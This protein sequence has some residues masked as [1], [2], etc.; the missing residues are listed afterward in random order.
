MFVFPQRSGMSLTIDQLLLDKP[1]GDWFTEPSPNFVAMATRIGPTTFCTVWLNRPSPKPPGRPKHLWSICHTSRLTGDIVQIFGNKF[2]AFGCLNQ[3]S[4]NN[5]LSSAM[6]RT[7]CQKW[8]DS[9][10]KQKRSS[11]LKGCDTQT[12]PIVEN[13]DS[14][15]GAEIKIRQIRPSAKFRV[16]WAHCT[17]LWQQQYPWAHA[18]PRH[19]LPIKSKPCKQWLRYWQ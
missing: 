11:N 17:V 5:V 4:K 19:T 10:E 14:L 3:K 9:I 1:V 6:R 12:E 18:R 15:L 2:W 13:N 7:D 8:R 16:P